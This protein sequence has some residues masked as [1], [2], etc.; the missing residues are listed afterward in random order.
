M[1]GAATPQ[2]V[3]LDAGA[4]AA[5]IATGAVSCVEVMRAYLDHIEV[6]NP[7]VTAIVGLRDRESVLAEAGERDVELRRSGARGPLHGLPVAVKDLAEAAGLPWTSGSPLFADRVGGADEPF[8]ARMRAAG[9]IVI[10]KTNVPELGLGSQSYN[11]VWGTTRNPYDPSRTAGGSSGGAAA[12]LALRMLPIA[13]GSD[14]MGS[15]RNPAAFCN[16]LGFRPSRGRVPRPGFVAQLS[17]VGPMGRT[18]SDV[19]MLLDV[20]AGAHPGAPLARTDRPSDG[21]AEIA[22]PGARIGW[23][24][25]LGGR[26]AT[27]PGLLDVCRGAA[28]TFAG[29]GATVEDVLPDTDFDALWT[30]FLTWRWWMTLELEPL[31]A[32]PAT[33]AMLK[34]EL[35]WEIE[36]GLELSALEVTRAMAVRD[37]WYATVLGLFERYDALLAPS[38]QV[39]PFSADVHWPTEIDG[40][41]MDTYHRW[42]ETVAPWSLAGVPVLGMPAGFDRRGL[43]AGVQLIGPPGA[44]RRVLGL[45]RSYE[46]AT[47]WVRRVRPAA[48]TVAGPPPP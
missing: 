32:D 42:M 33:R 8:V 38:A 30:A 26:L 28:E 37:A 35:V 29:L 5:E 39:F 6:V 43:P 19:T 41:P 47:Q 14:Y 34:P 24:G 36:R 31:Y 17:E 46:E 1:T 18:V 13:D 10:G 48:V 45:G 11:P 3:E 15:L 25:D 16:V 20:M 7:A 22:V 27:E 4:L 2:L 44:D 40:R 12:A 9:A 23:L 21:P